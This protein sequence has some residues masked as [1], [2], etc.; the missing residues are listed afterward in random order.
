MNALS[1]TPNSPESLPWQ[2]EKML[3]D[4]DEVV[5]L[6]DIESEFSP[7]YPWS[8]PQ[9]L[10][11]VGI[12][13][14]HTK[15]FG[16]AKFGRDLAFDMIKGGVPVAPWGSSALPMGVEIRRDFHGDQVEGRFIGAVGLL[17]VDQAVLALVPAA[18]RRFRKEG[19]F[20]NGWLGIWSKLE[21]RAKSELAIEAAALSMVGIFKASD[22]REIVGDDKRISRALARLVE[23]GRLTR[24]GKKKYVVTP[25]KVIERMDWT[26]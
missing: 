10:F 5:I 15:C 23:E 20:P 6:T 8:V 9:E 22:V 13:D 3:N 2:H 4:N 26:G 7:Y 12:Y 1:T 24:V 11:R 16:F 14:L 19:H 21:E 17:S 18:Q 25:P